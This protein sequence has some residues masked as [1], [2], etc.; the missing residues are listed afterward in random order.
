[1]APRTPK[2]LYARRDAMLEAIRVQYLKHG[3]VEKIGH[4][5][6]LEAPKKGRSGRSVT[7]TARDSKPNAGVKK[8]KSGSKR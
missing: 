1:V 6:D 7:G 4:R 3:T 2:R 8:A 5:T